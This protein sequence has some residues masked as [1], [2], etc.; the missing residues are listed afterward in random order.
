MLKSEKREGLKVSLRGVSQ[1]STLLECLLQAYCH[2]KARSQMS[3]SSGVKAFWVKRV[4][5]CRQWGAAEDVYATV[6]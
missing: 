3:P 2:G 1:G 4:A 6:M 5:V